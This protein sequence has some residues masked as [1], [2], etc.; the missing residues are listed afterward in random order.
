MSETEDDDYVDDVCHPGGRVRNDLDNTVLDCNYCHT[1]GHLGAHVAIHNWLSPLH[2]EKIA[3]QTCHIPERLVKPAQFQASDV[4]N[5]GTK[6]PSK[7]KH[8][9]VFYGPDM[10]YYNH[11]GN[12]SMMG[13]D[14]KPT[15]PFKPV[16][17]RYKDKIRPVNR[18]HSAWPGIEIEGKKGLIQPKMSNI[19]KMWEDP[20]ND[21]SNYPELSLI[22]DDNNDKIIE[23]NRPEEID[24]LI[25]AVTSMLNNINYPMEGKRVV[26]AMN[27]RIYTSGTD[28]YTIEKEEWESSPFANV[29][30]CNHDVYPA[31]SALGIN[32]CTECHSYSAEF[33]MASFWMN[34][35]SVL[36]F[37][38]LAL[39]FILILPD[40][41][42]SNYMLPTR[43]QIDANQFG[44]GILVL[45][46]SVALLVA[47]IKN[48]SERF[49][50]SNGIK[51]CMNLY[52]L[53]SLIITGISGFMMLISNS[54]IF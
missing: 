20:F 32:G 33:F 8:L 17:A 46:I 26:W 47:R 12:M 3:C 22:R 19:Y 16:L 38:G 6:I 41:Q 21:L 48:S 5:P 14:D 25:S 15:D 11:Y 28:Y 44:V 27:D 13:F 4:F 53:I 40:K 50:F 30:T 7:G 31:N 2:L 1:N 9:W 10:Q 29:H 51:N 43:F 52:I 45:F 18:V 23:V 24:A 42:L 36:F 35:L 34:L 37:M 39:M 54:W 49:S